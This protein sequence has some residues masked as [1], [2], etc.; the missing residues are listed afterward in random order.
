MKRRQILGPSKK[1][2]L[3][4]VKQN[5]T[6]KAIQI[7]KQFKCDLSRVHHARSEL[8]L[9]DKRP[10][11]PRKRTPNVFK[12]EQLKQRIEELL[13][14]TEMLKTHPNQEIRYVPTPEQISAARK[15]ETEL[16]EAKAVIAYLE[17]R[18]YGTSV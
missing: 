14:E 5:P 18:L 17:K 9:S 11:V 16:L 12:E 15:L 2:I 7:S 6:M 1:E 8:G 3:E 4:I 13:K 10:Y